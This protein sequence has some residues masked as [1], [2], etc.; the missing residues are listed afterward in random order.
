M[1]AESGD[2]EPIRLSKGGSVHTVERLIIAN[3]YNLRSIL[4]HDI[5]SSMIQIYA[6]GCKLQLRQIILIDTAL[7]RI[8][9]IKLNVPSGADAVFLVWGAGVVKSTHGQ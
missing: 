3:Y 1:C 5:T 9:I 2:V 4:I 8:I 7:L 6:H